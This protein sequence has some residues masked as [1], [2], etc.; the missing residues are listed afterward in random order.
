MNRIYGSVCGIRQNPAIFQL[1]GIR[2]DAGY[3][4]SDYPA[5]YPANRIFDGIS[6][7]LYRYEMLRFLGQLCRTGIWSKWYL[8]V[9]SASIRLKFIF[10]IILRTPPLTNT[11]NSL[12]RKYLTLILKLWILPMLGKFFQQISQYHIS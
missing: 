9:H 4:V 1:S 11:H 2:S 12:T 3:L 6:F 7:F 10:D 5:G 8:R